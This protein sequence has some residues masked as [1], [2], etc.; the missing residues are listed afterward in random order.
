DIGKM[1]GVSA[2]KVGSVAKA[3]GMKTDEYGSWYHDKSPYSNKEVDTF[4]YNDKAVKKFR[5]LL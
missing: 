2:Q 4:R 1:F 3:N 5:N